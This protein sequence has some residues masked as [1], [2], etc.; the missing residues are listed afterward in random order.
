VIRRVAFGKALM[1]GLAGAMAWEAAAR[2]A[3]ALGLPIFDVVYIM[4]T[5]VAGDSPAS[6]WWPIGL[7]VHLLVGAIWAVFYAYFFWSEFPWKP[8]VQGMVF[9]LGPAIVTGLVMV[10]QLALMHPLV[11]HGQL[12]KP[13]VFARHLGWG[14]P[15]G[16]ILGHLIYGAVLGA[17]Y[18]RPVGYPVRRHA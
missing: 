10:P 3:I 1:A 11:L 7:A 12:P 18:V 8:Y 5:L 6:V 15:V 16:D 4:G 13:G 2:L 17:I 14:G 9:A